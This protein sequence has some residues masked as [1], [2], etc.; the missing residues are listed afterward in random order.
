MLRHPTTAAGVLLAAWLVCGTS[1]AAE[2]P[3]A[4]GAPRPDPL[5]ARA[6]VPPATHVSAFQRYRAHRDAPV[7]S[8]RDANDTVTRIG[9]WRAYA[10]EAAA[11]E[12]AA[13]QSQPRPA[14]CHPH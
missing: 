4:T 13:S 5:D 10:R 2:A 14:C 12:G 8:W 3:P 1:L 9:G 11:P 7:G 6:S